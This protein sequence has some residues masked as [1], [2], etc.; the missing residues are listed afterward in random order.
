MRNNCV[1]QVKNIDALFNNRAR[2]YVRANT[3]DNLARGEVYIL[4][5]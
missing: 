3:I 4:Y 2:A 1:E 5:I